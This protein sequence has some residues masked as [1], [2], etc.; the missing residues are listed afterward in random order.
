MGLEIGGGFFVDLVD[1]SLRA[2]RVGKWNK[3]SRRQALAWYMAQVKGYEYV[4]GQAIR[5]KDMQ[6]FL[7]AHRSRMS[8][9]LRDYDQYMLGAEID[10]DSWEI[11]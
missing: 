10:M 11:K 9:I 8:K 6:S 7:K 3:R 2:I 5:K 1:K 4:P